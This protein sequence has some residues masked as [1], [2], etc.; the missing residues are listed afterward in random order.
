MI[1]TLRITTIVVVLL[2]VVFFVCAV[3]F[4]SRGDERIKAV[5]NS[6]SVIER[7]NSAADTKVKAG[8]GR[9]S[10]LVEQAQRLAA[11]LNPP[12]RKEPVRPQVSRPPVDI[13]PPRADV[14]AKFKVCATVV[15]Q[16]DP[17]LSLACIEE[18]G[19][20]L[21]WA[22][23]GATINHLVFEEIK[24]GV[25]VVRDK[26]RTFEV[27]IEERP[28]TTSLLEGSAGSPA[29]AR[30]G[31]AARTVASSSK[32]AG[33]T[34]PGTSGRAALRSPSRPGPPE[35][36]PEESARMEALVDRLKALQENPDP[37]KS[38]E[39]RNK[40]VAEIMK[41]LMQGHESTRITPQE[42]DNL[43][44]MGNDPEGGETAP[45]ENL[46]PVP[47][48]RDARTYRPARKVPQLPSRYQDL[49]R[50]R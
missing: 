7:F 15:H 3:V 47:G 33:L 48:G 29:A 6:P 18:P 1:K 5:L 10:P 13:Q 34:R 36:T 31:T 50:G 28:A 25:V 17:K 46:P 30:V 35:L 32:V 38:S 2:A 40:E 8:V 43:E 27:K 14:S 45:N 49:R 4:G 22:R 37:S 19:K 44:H 20:G 39:E 24:E 41:Q 9:L 16:T 23:Q 21:H 12:V 11:Y 42:A 26:E